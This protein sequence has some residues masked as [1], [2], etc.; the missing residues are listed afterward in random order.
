MTTT[1]KVRNSTE[2]APRA[3]GKS[4]PSSKPTTQKVASRRS[5]VRKQQK[6]PTVQ[7]CSAAASSSARDSKQSRL[8]ATLRAKPGATIEEMM[9]L[10]GWQAHS[11]RG[12]ISGVLRKRLGL[13]VVCATAEGDGARVY[14]ITAPAE[15]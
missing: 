10:T 2:K 6:A 5:V 13:N 3:Q 12:A 15:A 11:V 14:R 8:I 9:T 1:P 4:A 7:A